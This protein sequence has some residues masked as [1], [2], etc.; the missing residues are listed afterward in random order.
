ML[1]T[2]GVVIIG[3]CIALLIVNCCFIRI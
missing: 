3:L 2:I 1:C